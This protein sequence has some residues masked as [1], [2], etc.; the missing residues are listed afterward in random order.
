VLVLSRSES[1]KVDI[2]DGQIVVTVL[3]IR[4]K[5]V[6]LGFEAP[7]SVSINRREVTERL[8]KDA[9]SPNAD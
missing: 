9:A 8:D 4:G 3:E 7:D 1:Q 5:L 6:R 2:A